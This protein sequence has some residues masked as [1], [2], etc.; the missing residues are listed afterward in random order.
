MKCTAHSLR[1]FFPIQRY[2]LITGHDWHFNKYQRL[3]DVRNEE[4][5]LDDSIVAHVQLES[6]GRVKTEEVS[7]KLVWI[8]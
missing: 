2:S 4:R 1:E 6:W 8:R 3:V 7:A 5:F